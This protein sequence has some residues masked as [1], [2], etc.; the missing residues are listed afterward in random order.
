MANLADLARRPATEGTAPAA[1]PGFLKNSPGSLDK[2][3]GGIRTVRATK[4]PLNCVL[5]SP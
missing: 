3:H 4:N 2:S 5:N 1:R